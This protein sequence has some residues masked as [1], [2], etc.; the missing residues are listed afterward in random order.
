MKNIVIIPNINKDKEL[1]VTK[2]VVEKLISCGADVYIESKY[3]LDEKNIRKY[4]IFPSCAELVIVVGGDGSF[5]DASSKAIEN[6]IPIFGVNLGKFGYLSEVEPDNLDIL[7]KLFSGDFQVKEKMLLTVSHISGDEETKSDRL[8]VNDIIITR[9]SYMGI[10]DFSLET[11]NGE[12]VKYRADGMIFSTPAGSTA[13]SLS[14]GGPVM[15]HGVDSLLATP[16]CPHSFFN[17]SIIFNP[18]EIIKL[19]NTGDADLSISV[20]GRHFKNA[21]PGESCTVCMA[22]EKIKTL[23]FNENNMFSTLFRKMRIMEDIK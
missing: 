15:A 17:R 23:T 18:T 19:K 16:I 20:D 9:E 22:P 11:K 13:Y 2:S 6:N 5:I 7:E 12:K 3:R 8:A 14:A 4:D 10:A 1:S 21:R